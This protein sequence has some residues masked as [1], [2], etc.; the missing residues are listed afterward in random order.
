MVGL[1][2]KGYLK[3]DKKWKKVKQTNVEYMFLAEGLEMKA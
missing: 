1:T 2:E 3:K